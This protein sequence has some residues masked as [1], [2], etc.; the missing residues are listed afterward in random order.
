[1]IIPPLRGKDE[2]GSG[3]YLASRGDRIHKGIDIACYP[4]STL[5]ADF[6]AQVIRVGY[7]YSKHGK[8]G[9]LRLV[10]LAVDAQTRV[11]YM[12]IYPSV[13]PGQFVNKGDE[14]GIVQDLSIIYPGMTNHYHMEV[15]VEGCHVN[16][17]IWLEQRT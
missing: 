7:P 12:Y 6:D 5:L 3:H 11:K 10:E 9:Y 1:M 17:E 13:S 8:K 14:L 15:W 4:S 2:W 16:P